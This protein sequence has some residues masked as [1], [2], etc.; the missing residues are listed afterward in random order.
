MYLSLVS[1][2]IY[3]TYR[4]WYTFA[5]YTN[6]VDRT[7][8]DLELWEKN[9][10]DIIIL[11]A[12]AGFILYRLYKVLGQEVGFKPG[13]APQEE[14]APVPVSRKTASKHTASDEIKDKIRDLQA[15]DTQFDQTNFLNGATSAFE[16]ILAAFNQGDRS[17]LKSLLTKQFYPIFD[18]AIATREKKK[19]IWDNTLIRVQS[20]EI[21]DVKIEKQTQVIIT[22]KFVSDQILVTKNA[23]GN[24]IEGDPDQIEVLTD[25]W[26][27]TRDATSDDPNWLL[28]Q[29]STSE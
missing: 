29:T 2:N 13:A 19:E 5:E 1:R 12:I 22:V 20:S 9:I 24:I 8:P 3:S 16:M 17:T 28:A 18:K 23:R 7:L 15:L 6:K 26:T 14:L 10:M 21:T 25:I 4:F 11:A 27:F